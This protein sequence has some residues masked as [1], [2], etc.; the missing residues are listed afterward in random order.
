MEGDRGV[1]DPSPA[2]EFSPLPSTFGPFG[3]GVVFSVTFILRPERFGGAPA[4]IFV[5]EA[6][7]I[8]RTDAGTGIGSSQENVDIVV[9]GF[10]VLLGA[11][12]D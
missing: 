12:P 3:V 7:A 9:K 5:I 10:S 2:P 8:F 11:F 4:V 6:L 1:E